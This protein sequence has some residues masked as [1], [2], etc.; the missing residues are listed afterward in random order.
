MTWQRLLGLQRKPSRRVEVARSYSYK[1]NMGNYESRDFFCSQKA[2]CDV[3]DAEEV[4]RRVYEYCR[5]QVLASVEEERQAGWKATA[6]P[7]AVANAREFEKRS[8]AK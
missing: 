6:H 7:V 4:G 5:R 8:V 1:M 3:D 2:E